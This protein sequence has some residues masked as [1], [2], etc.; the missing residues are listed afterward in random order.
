MVDYGLV[1]LE[2]RWLSGKVG[3]L[4]TCNYSS[5]K[6]EC[7]D[8]YRGCIARGHRSISSGSFP[9]EAATAIEADIAATLPS[10]KLFLPEVGPMHSDLKDLL[11]AWMTSRIDEGLGFY[12]PGTAKL[13]AML[14]INMN[15][16]EQAFIALRNYLER[17]CPRAFYGGQSTKDDVSL[18]VCI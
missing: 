13:G 9:L 15:S 17:G 12:V 11:V 4:K 5:V 2:T 16:N 7:A 1:L 14:L 3:V 18:G 8:S 6:S 10:I